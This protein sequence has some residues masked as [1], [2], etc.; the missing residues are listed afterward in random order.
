MTM[1]IAQVSAHTSPLAPLG[2]RETGG[3]NVYVLELSRELARLGYEVDIFTRQ[4]GELPEVEDLE[5]NLRLVRIEAGPREPV[6][7][8]EIVGCLPQFAEGMEAFAAAQGKPYD[9]IHSHYWQSGWAGGLL[10]RKLNLP[11]AVMF[12]TLGEVKNRA[13]ISEGEPRSRIHHEHN[14]AR[15]ATAIVTAS[16]HER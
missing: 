1:R 3:M 16:D 15:R 13:R 2:G 11:H 10:A 14:I 6:E 4:D 9:V 8:E 7:K 12:H 5:P